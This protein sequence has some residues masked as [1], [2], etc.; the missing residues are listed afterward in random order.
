MTKN[1]ENGAKYNTVLMNAA[2]A[3]KSADV[4]KDFAEGILI[5]KNSI[6]S[7][8]AFEKLEEFI[9]VSNRNEYNS[10]NKN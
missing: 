6:E 4:A 8:K 5:A 7:G 10:Q 9:E 2:I 1:E 3:L